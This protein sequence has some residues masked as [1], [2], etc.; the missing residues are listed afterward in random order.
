MC[1]YDFGEPHLK[2]LKAKIQT[3]YYLLTRLYFSLCGHLR[4]M[5]PFPTTIELKGNCICGDCRCWNQITS[6]N[7]DEH[8][9]QGREMGGNLTRCESP[10]TT[11]PHDYPPLLLMMFSDV[12]SFYAITQR[13]TVPLPSSSIKRRWLLSSTQSACP[14]SFLLRQS[15]RKL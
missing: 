15:G 13:Q 5:L 3:P 4:K 8:W 9:F 12:T 1:C 2:T 6:N 10:S 14:P 7:S 11:M